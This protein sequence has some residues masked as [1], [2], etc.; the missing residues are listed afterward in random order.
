M[1]TKIIL[2]QLK[3]RILQT[4]IVMWSDL[5]AG[6]AK[7]LQ[8]LE[9]PLLCFSWCKSPCD[10]VLQQK[11]KKQLREGENLEETDAGFDDSITLILPSHR[12][13]PI[14]IGWE[15]HSH[16]AT[17]E[18]QIMTVRQHLVLRDLISNE[19]TASSGRSL[20]RRCWPWSYECLI[21]NPRS[22]SANTHTHTPKCLECA[23]CQLNTVDR[24]HVEQNIC[25]FASR[26]QQNKI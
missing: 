2:L 16:P 11:E 13:L 9:D 20:D 17:E 19:L 5:S 12:N 15:T 1:R 8:G 18:E 6:E 26:G 14:H 10:A 4:L 3:N 25:E 21:S 7:V 22:I 23:D 24:T